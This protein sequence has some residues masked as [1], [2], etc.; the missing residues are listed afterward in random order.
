MEIKVNEFRC[1]FQKEK[2]ASER[3]LIALAQH[4]IGNSIFNRNKITNRITEKEKNRRLGELLS[5]MDELQTCRTHTTKAI[6]NA[7][8]YLI[9]E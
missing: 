5:R 7:E 2:L 3:M 4:N 6:S 8:D 9:A 1:L